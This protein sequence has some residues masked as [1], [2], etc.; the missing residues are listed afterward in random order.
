MTAEV[1]SSRLERNS[2]SAVQAILGI[3]LIILFSERS[4]NMRDV[5]ALILYKLLEFVPIRGIII[6]F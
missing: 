6:T 3:F 2:F 5:Y 4:L 1:I